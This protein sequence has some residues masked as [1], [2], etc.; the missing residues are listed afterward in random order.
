MFESAPDVWS[1]DLLRKNLG[2]GKNHAYDLVNSRKIH[3]VKVGQRILI[4]KQGVVD[5]LRG[6]EYNGSRNDGF[7]PLSGKE[8][9]IA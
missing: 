9:T 3:S 2:I 1:V 5:F 7:T 6:S 4:P 8:S